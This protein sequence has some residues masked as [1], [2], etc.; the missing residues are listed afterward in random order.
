[1]P[2][3][4]GARRSPCARAATAPGRRS[5]LLAMCPPA[6]DCAGV[7]SSHSVSWTVV[8]AV[9]A[10]LRSCRSPS[11]W[12]RRP[13]VRSG[14]ALTARAGSARGSRAPP[15]GIWGDVRRLGGRWG[16]CRARWRSSDPVPFVWRQCPITSRGEAVVAGRRLAPGD[17]RRGWSPSRS[18]R[19]AGLRVRAE[20]RGTRLLAVPGRRRS[21]RR[22][23]R[24][25]GAFR[26]V[27]GRG[28]RR[29]WWGWGGRTRRLC[30]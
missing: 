2:H 24:L 9:L 8:V 28:C 20:E 23:A 4:I 18:L 14:P 1:M 16:Q 27:R 7:A 13:A 10:T 19:V 29:R 30:G 12:R 22:R 5:N 11:S 26:S 21:G 15:C 17:A 6:R 25:R 3:T